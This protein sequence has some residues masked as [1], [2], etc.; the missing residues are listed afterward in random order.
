MQQKVIN[1]L[2]C[3]NGDKSLCRHWHH[4]FVAALGQYD[5]A[6]EETVQHPV[7]ETHFGKDLDKVV[8]ELKI[9]HGG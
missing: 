7:K 9:M 2:R 8:R 4:T 5:Q 3:V 6:H 1:N